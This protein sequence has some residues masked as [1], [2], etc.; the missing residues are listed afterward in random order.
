LCD[1]FLVSAVTAVADHEIARLHQELEQLHAENVCLSRLLDLSGL[2]TDPVPEQP[3]LAV[4][5]PGLV[6]MSSPVE[7]KL[8]LCADRFGRGPLLTDH[9]CRSLVADFDGPAVMLEALASAKAARA[10]GFTRA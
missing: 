9:T 6:M 7:E 2:G 10:R 4:A 3:P 8:A 5:P 1:D